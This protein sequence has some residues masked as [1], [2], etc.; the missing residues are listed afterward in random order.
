MTRN[1]RG[2]Y[3]LEQRPMVQPVKDLVA[4]LCVQACLKNRR[5]NVEGQKTDG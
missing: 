2:N 5:R 3:D 4:V 1:Y